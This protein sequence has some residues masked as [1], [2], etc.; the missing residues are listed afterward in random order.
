MQKKSNMPNDWRPNW[1]QNVMA[2]GKWVVMNWDGSIV[3]ILGGEEIKFR[4]SLTRE[5]SKL[6]VP[7]VES[8]SHWTL[9]FLVGYWTAAL[10]VLLLL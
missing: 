4:D 2:T 1:N 9:P 7:S 6:T 10:Q 5:V 8:G 3:G